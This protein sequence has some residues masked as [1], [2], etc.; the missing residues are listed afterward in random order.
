MHTK[1]TGPAMTAAS[2][3]GPRPDDCFSVKGPQVKQTSTK[4]N[5]VTGIHGTLLHPHL[6]WCR[7]AASERARDSNLAQASTQPPPTAPLSAPA[8]PSSSPHSPQQPSSSLTQLLSHPRTF[9]PIPSG[10]HSANQTR[11]LPLVS[12][13]HRHSSL[14]SFHLSTPLEA[15]TCLWQ[16][17]P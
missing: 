17:K 2:S 8:A 9:P 3:T 14:G 4:G 11:K 7:S 15:S 16:G 6:P 12:P 10:Y 1:Q 5:T 13:K